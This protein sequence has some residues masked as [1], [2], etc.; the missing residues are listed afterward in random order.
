M[1]FAAAANPAHTQTTATATCPA[2]R[3]PSTAASARRPTRPGP[4]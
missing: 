4:R 3:S 2:N 1:P